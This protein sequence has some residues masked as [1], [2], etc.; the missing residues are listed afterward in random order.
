MVETPEGPLYETNAILR[1][2]GRHSKRPSLYGSNIF[3][4][5]LVDQWLDWGL[6]ELEPH[7][8]VN[9]LPYLGM[10]PHIKE[11]SE[12]AQKNLDAALEILEDH[13]KNK[14]FLVQKEITIADIQLASILHFSFQWLFDEKYRENIPNIT[15]WYIVVTSEKAWQKEYGRPIL[16]KT[17][18]KL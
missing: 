16:C 14:G 11:I 12:K 2:I 1:Y 6:T 10:V 17:P 18:L 5:A 7:V 3:E 15:K 13:L 4:Q 8:I 9:N